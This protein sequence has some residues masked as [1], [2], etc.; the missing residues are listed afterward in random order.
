MRN[1][2]FEK[3]LG[4]IEEVRRAIDPDK[5]YCVILHG[6]SVAAKRFGHDQVRDIKNTLR[7]L[8]PR[9]GYIILTADDIDGNG[10]PDFNSNDADLIINATKDINLTAAL[11]L[12]PSNI[13]FITSDTFL[14]WLGGGMIALREDRIG[15]LQP[16]DVYV[17]NTLSSSLFW[18]MP[19]ANHCESFAIE[20]LRKKHS[21]ME[22]SADNIIY[23]EEYY[24]EYKS[25]K[26]VINLSNTHIASE[27]IA[28]FTRAIAQH[29][30]LNSVS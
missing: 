13:T 16:Q 24:K 19:G 22:S 14:F 27:D 17:L 25:F 5:S 18:R 2:S 3:T 11:F 10:G 26:G 30:L 21:R 9:N 29:N 15:T 8:F 12:A 7:T 6:G 1:F 4:K 23:P 28:K 20:H